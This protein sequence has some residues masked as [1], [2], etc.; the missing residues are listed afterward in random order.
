MSF[1]TNPSNIAPQIWCRWCTTMTNK[2]TEDKLFEILLSLLTCVTHCHLTWAVCS[3][4]PCI[5]AISAR[6]GNLFYC[7]MFIT[8]AIWRHYYQL[9]FL[10]KKKRVHSRHAVIPLIELLLYICEIVR[11][12]V[13][14]AHLQAMVGGDKMSSTIPAPMEAKSGSHLIK[15][16]V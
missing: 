4:A 10:E 9:N 1:L 14:H 6:G 11:C 8:C 15:W 16:R 2:K 3:S 5:K 7:I 12:R 13:W